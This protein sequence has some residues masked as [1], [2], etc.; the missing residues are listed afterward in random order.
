MYWF[1]RY[2]LQEYDFH[3]CIWTVLERSRWPRIRATNN[4]EELDKAVQFC[5]LVKQL[6]K[7]NG[8]LITIILLLLPIL[9]DGPGKSSPSQG[10]QHAIEDGQRW[11]RGGGE[12]LTARLLTNCSI[13]QR[14][15]LT[16]QRISQV[17]E[18]EYHKDT[19]K[20]EA[21]YFFVAHSVLPPPPLPPLLL[22]P[23]PPLPQ[24]LPLPHYYHHYHYHHH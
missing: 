8:F 5:T 13:T 1:V 11:G 22:L 18:T 3:E 4:E 24:T 15:I 21:G 16:P 2:P 9:Q 17:P 19:C 14:N 20:R 6:F 7:F 12:I 23:P 10:Q